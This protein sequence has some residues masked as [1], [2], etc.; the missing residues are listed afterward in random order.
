M[1]EKVIVSLWCPLVK[2]FELK[3]NSG[4]AFFCN[5]CAITMIKKRLKKDD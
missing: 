3:V 4:L 2:A 5:A 1:K